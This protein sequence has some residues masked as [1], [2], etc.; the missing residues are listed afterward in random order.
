MKLAWAT[1]IH[2]DM[3]S[4]DAFEQGLLRQFGDAD[5]VLLTG[6]IANGRSIERW[7]ITLSVKLDRPIYFVLGN[8]DYYHRSIAQVRESVLARC[9]REPNLFY[10]SDGSIIDLGEGASLVGHDGWGD[11]QL[12]DFL[13]CMV[14][15]NDHRL[16]EE[17]KTRDREALKPRLQALG[18]EAAD[19]L[20]DA[21]SRA[22]VRGARRVLVAT[23]VPPFVESS[24]YQGKIPEP[25]S[26]WIPNCTCKATGDVLLELSE[27]NPGVE[28]TV[29]CGHTHG[30]GST[31][32]RDNLL[33][34]TGGAEYQAPG[35][36]GWIRPNAD[37]ILG[38]P[39]DPPEP[40]K[41]R[42][43]SL[44]RWLTGSG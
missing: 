40:P 42:S 21:I 24:W 16:I 5:A 41:K 2:L 34:H 33:V 44:L 22:I 23:H 39:E 38:G 29:F 14:E 6:D 30:A 35:V 31:R 7:L 20:R 10:L 43:F 13:G 11:A 25:D 36:A 37:P 9:A 1:D 26:H 15:L 32:M 4:D 17:L 27:Q 8:H 18:Q 12:G 3:C 28:L 19:S